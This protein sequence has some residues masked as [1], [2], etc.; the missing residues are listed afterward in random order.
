MATR[1][2]KTELGNALDTQAT[3]ADTFGKTLVKIMP[4]VWTAPSNDMFAST[5]RAHIVDFTEQAGKFKIGVVSYDM[6]DNDSRAQWM[7]ERIRMVSKSYG[8]LLDDIEADRADSTAHAWDKAIYTNELMKAKAEEN[9]FR[10]FL[11]LIY[12]FTKRDVG[13]LKLLRNGKLSFSFENDDGDRESKSEFI[14]GIF[15]ELKV[16]TGES[17]PAAPRVDKASITALADELAMRLAGKPELSKDDKASLL[18][19]WA[20]IGNALDAKPEE[21]AQAYDDEYADAS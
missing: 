3:N 5:I 4:D 11:K 13:D 17:K 6:S 14:A 8:K 9:A 20:E 18:A 2:Y 1:N 15:R 16:S 19:L 12:V 7:R 10:I 21:L